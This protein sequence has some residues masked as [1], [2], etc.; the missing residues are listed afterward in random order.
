M[1][2]LK[3]TAGLI[4]SN[5]KI[6]LACHANPDGDAIGSMLGLGLAL[7]KI[8]KSVTMLCPDPIPVRYIKLPGVHLIKR[9][10]KGKA[11]LA[12]S[13]DCASI[14]QLS[15]IEEIFEQSERIVEID[16]HVYRTRFGDVQLVDKNAC[17]VGEIVY[18][19]LQQ[20]SI[21][22][23]KKVAE[24]LLTSTLIETSSFSRQ[25]VQKSTFEICARLLEE[26][27][28]FQKISERYYWRKRL[29]TMHLSGLC[30]MRSKMRAND[31]LV[32]SIVYKKDFE[33][34]KGKQEDVDA[35]ADD[36]MMIENVKIALLFREI[37]D[38]MFRVSL[39][40]RAGIDIGYLASLY[41]GGGHPDVA[42][43]RIHNNQKT[44]EKLITQACR[45][46]DKKK[47]H[48]K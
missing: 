38:N 20:L 2:R 30:L 18:L 19:L 37:D 29:S 15:K 34:F 39:R 13:V 28:S 24:C 17:S 47:L 16:H 4:K 31:Q 44:V 43:C 45:L 6:F 36:M 12:N 27:V 9:Q 5:R 3:V 48:R 26:G 21:P 42:G 14:I 33:A 23:D 46:I 25:D 1:N 41:G 40:S 22:M 35:V 11:D 8:G 32:W 10:C 7:M